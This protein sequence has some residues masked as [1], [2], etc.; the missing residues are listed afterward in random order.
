MGVG[1]FMVRKMVRHATAASFG[2]EGETE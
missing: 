1:K 2:G